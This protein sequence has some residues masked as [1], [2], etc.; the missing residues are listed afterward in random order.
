[1]RAN[2]TICPTAKFHVSVDQIRKGL[3]HVTGVTALLL[4]P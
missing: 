4:P 2:L 3:G 1:M